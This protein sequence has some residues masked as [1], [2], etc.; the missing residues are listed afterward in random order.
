MK[1]KASK[2]IFIKK[3]PLPNL[4]FRTQSKRLSLCLTATLPKCGARLLAAGLKFWRKSRIHLSRGSVL[5]KKE[6][7]VKVK[8]ENLTEVLGVFDENLTVLMKET[9]VSVFVDENEFVIKGEKKNVDIAENALK[10][11]INIAAAGEKI[12]KLRV[13]YCVEMAKGNVEETEDIS[14]AFSSVVAITEKGRRVKCKTLGQKKYADAINKSS[15]VF[16]VGPA[17]TGKT[18]LAVAMAAQAHE[19]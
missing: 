12:D 16:G 8:P 18:Y 1:S 9:D 13:L 3:S 6:V 4:T 2:S 15:V 17:G 14:K 19:A 5:E 7:K 11:L 10:K